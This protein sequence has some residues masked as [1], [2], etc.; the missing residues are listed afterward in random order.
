[1]A[2]RVAARAEQEIRA[3]PRLHNAFYTAVT[4][5][6]ALRH[7]AGRARDRVRGA[8]AGRGAAPVAGQEPEVEARRRA[9]VAHRLGLD[10]TLT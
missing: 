10:G 1:V 7:L 4:R 9:A 2:I 8:E 3:Y 6:P 5:N